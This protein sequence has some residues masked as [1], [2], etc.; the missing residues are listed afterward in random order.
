MEIAATISISLL[1]YSSI[2]PLQDGVQDQAVVCLLLLN[3]SLDAQVF[4]VRE[5]FSDGHPSGL[6][7]FQ[8]LAKEL[9]GELIGMLGSG[10]QQS[11][12]L[13]FALLVMDDDL[14]DSPFQIVE[15]LAMPWQDD[16]GREV[17]YFLQRIEVI[18]QWVGAIALRVEA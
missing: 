14:V 1:F 7:V 3:L 5:R 15:G 18:A 8:S 9:L 10:I 11:Q 13:H 6:V 17:S 2:I 16:A 12:Y 4:Q